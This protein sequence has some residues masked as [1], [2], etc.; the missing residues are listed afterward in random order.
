MSKPV[1]H[2]RFAPFAWQGAFEDKTFWLR[3]GADAVV[4]GHSLSVEGV[5][6]PPLWRWFDHSRSVWSENVA[7]LFC[8]CGS[9]PVA[10]IARVWQDGREPVAFVRYQQ[11]E[12]VGDHSR[13]LIFSAVFHRGDDVCCHG[14][15]LLHE[16]GTVTAHCRVHDLEVTSEVVFRS[17]GQAGGWCG[18]LTADPMKPKR[19]VLR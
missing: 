19:V 3:T 10:D 1:R 6:L 9:G 2:R 7:R 18:N 4:R 17:L 13:M 15:L 14:P 16:G 5:D 11:R 12:L 8:H